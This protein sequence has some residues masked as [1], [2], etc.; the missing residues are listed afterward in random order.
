MINNETQGWS[1]DDYEA[2]GKGNGEDAALDRN[3]DKA[4][5]LH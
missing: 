4:D 2:G 5:E 3:S 1:A